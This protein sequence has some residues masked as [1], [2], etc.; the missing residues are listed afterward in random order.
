MNLRIICKFLTSIRG[1][2]FFCWFAQHSVSGA[3][4]PVSPAWNFSFVLCSLKNFILV[5]RCSDLRGLVVASAQFWCIGPACLPK[6]L[7]GDRV[8]PHDKFVGFL[9]LFVRTTQTVAHC[10]KVRWN[11]PVV[12]WAEQQSGTEEKQMLLRCANPTR[13]SGTPGQ[14]FGHTGVSIVPIVPLVCPRCWELYWIAGIEP[15]QSYPQ[16]WTKTRD[17]RQAADFTCTVWTA[18]VIKTKSSLQKTWQK[19]VKRLFDFGMG[20]KW[21]DL[22]SWHSVSACTQGREPSE[23]NL[24]SIFDAPHRVLLTGINQ[25]QIGFYSLFSPGGHYIDSAANWMMTMSSPGNRKLRWLASP[26]WVNL[27]IRCLES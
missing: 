21:S 23:L 15:A 17:S 14:Q 27:R 8:G 2:V 1:G 16:K 20:G 6:L 10:R 11:I 12:A 5:Q 3:S 7:L 9:L 25:F 22:Q 24:I 26:L 4:A 13:N 19:E 18:M